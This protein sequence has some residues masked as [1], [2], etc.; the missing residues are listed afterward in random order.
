MMSPSTLPTDTYAKAVGHTSDV[1]DLPPQHVVPPKA[2]S[3][4]GEDNLST[5]TPTG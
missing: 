5:S 2:T 3:R 1:P 4:V